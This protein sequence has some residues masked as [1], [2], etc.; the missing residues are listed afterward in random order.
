MYIK[1][2]WL[3]QH[4]KPREKEQ[5]YGSNMFIEKIAASVLLNMFINGYE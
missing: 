5:F 1:A 3:K 4:H 2:E